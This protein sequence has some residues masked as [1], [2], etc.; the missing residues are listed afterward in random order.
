MLLRHPVFPDQIRLDVIGD[1][2]GPLPPVG[3][4]AQPALGGEHPVGGG[5]EGELHRSLE[6]AAQ[7]GG[8]AGVG[9]HH[10]RPLSTDDL[11]QQLSGTEH[12]SGVPPVHGD[13]VVA[14][15]RGHDLRDIDTAVGGH[16]DVVSLRLQLLGQLYD[17]GL[18][19]PISRPIVAI[20]IFMSA[21]PF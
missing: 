10:V 7:E 19:P 9:V 12:A 18:R 11:L 15:A 6:G 2:D 16:H 5:D 14:D 21:A 17:M 1:G 13:L 3:E 8:D 4:V 20:R